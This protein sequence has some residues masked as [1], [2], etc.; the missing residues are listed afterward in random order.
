[1]ITGLNTLIKNCIVLAC[2][3]TMVPASTQARELVLTLNDGSRVAFHLSE[4]NKQTAC[5]TVSDETIVINGITYAR[6]QFKELRIY[7]ELPEGV[8]IADA[9]QGIGVGP[10]APADNAIYDLSGRR[11]CAAEGS[12]AQLRKGVYIINHKKVVKP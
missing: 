5:L 1:M 7:K 2:V 3:C 11:I 8:D 12:Q 10:A 4:D 9:I 6:D